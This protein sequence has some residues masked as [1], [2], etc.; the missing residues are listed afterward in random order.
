VQALQA[1]I[2]DPARTTVCLPRGKV[3]QLDQPVYVRVAITRIIG[4]GSTFN[5]AS[6]GQF[7]IDDGS[8]PA[9]LLQ[10]IFPGSE[11]IPLTKR[12]SRTLIIETA[13]FNLSILGGGETYVTDWIGRQNVIDNPRLW[14]SPKFPSS[15]SL[16]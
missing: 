13:G 1:A 12:T 9:V 4:T 2:D 14:G 10:N 7:T 6:S 3:Y 8:A 11:F 5:T 15:C 16:K